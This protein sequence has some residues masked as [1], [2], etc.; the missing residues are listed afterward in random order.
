MISDEDGF[1]MKIIAL[2]EIYNFI[3]FSFFIWSF[4]MFEKIKQNFMG[5]L[6]AYK[7]LLP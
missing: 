5:I 7:R 3:V 4:K 6:I 2:D 1:Y